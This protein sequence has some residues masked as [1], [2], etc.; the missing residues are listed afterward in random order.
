MVLRAFILSELLLVPLP[1]RLRLLP[2]LLVHVLL[3]LM[4]FVLT[5]RLQ[6]Q[7]IHSPVLQV[8]AERQHAHLVHQMEL[9]GPVEV[10]DRAERLG[11]AVKEVFVVYERVVVAK[12]A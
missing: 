10:E 8:I 2:H 11:M 7:L 3:P 9:P 4:V 5:T 6:I 1:Q 12:L